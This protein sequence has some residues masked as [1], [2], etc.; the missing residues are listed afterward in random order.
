MQEWQPNLPRYLTWYFESVLDVVVF[1]VFAYMF[2]Q[3]SNIKTNYGQ[4][5]EMS[6]VWTKG[7]FYNKGYW[8][9]FLSDFCLIPKPF[10][11]N[12]ICLSLCLCVFCPCSQKVSLK[13]RVFSSPRS[14]GTKGKG[15]PQHGGCEIQVFLIIFFYC[16]EMLLLLRVHREQN[17]KT[18]TRAGKAEKRNRKSTLGSQPFPIE[19]CIP[20]TLYP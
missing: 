16:F 5:S 9:A 7:W 15:S 18:S 17:Q 20:G 3:K 1:D 10:E 8:G 2:V 4:N 12:Y 14:S 6:H 19:Q 13:E 11:S